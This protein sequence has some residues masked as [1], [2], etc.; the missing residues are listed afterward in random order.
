MGPRPPSVQWPRARPHQP[1]KGSGKGRGR[2][3]PAHKQIPVP[4]PAGTS[5]SSPAES[6]AVVAAK[7]SKLE[8]ACLPRGQALEKCDQQDP[9]SCGLSRQAVGRVR[10]GKRLELAKQAIATA[11]AEQERLQEDCNI[12]PPDW[13]S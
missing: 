1:P 3:Q 4:T 9:D 10:A 12:G 13:R 7:F 2:S 6:E 11:V 8:V 5:R